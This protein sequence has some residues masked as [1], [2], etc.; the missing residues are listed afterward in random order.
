M[1]VRYNPANSYVST[2]SKLN[3]AA[4]YF[5][6]LESAYSSLNI[7]DNIDDNVFTDFDLEETSSQESLVC[8]ICA[9]TLKTK[10]RFGTP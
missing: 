10:A 9:K 2:A 3:M 5:S 1:S 4:N 8:S 6:E 7:E